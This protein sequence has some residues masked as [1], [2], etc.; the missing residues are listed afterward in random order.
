MIRYDTYRSNAAEL[1]VMRRWVFCGLALSLLIHAGILYYFYLHRME[2]AVFA[3][4]RLAPPRVFNMKRVSLPAPPP[5]PPAVERIKVPDKTATVTPITIPQD[6]PIVGEVRVAPQITDLAAKKVF[7]EK[8]RVDMAALDQMTK[9][10]A[11]SRNEMEKELNN[12]AQSL[13]KESPRS[14]RQPVIMASG[15][16]PAAAGKG[17]SN[18]SIPG[19]ASVDDMLSH[20][21][22][23]H[24]GDKAGM[25]GGALFEYDSYSL[26]PEAVEAMEKLGALIRNNPQATFAI[27][28]HTDSFGPPDYNQVLSEMRAAAVRDWLVLNLHIDPV[29]IQTRGFGNTRPL[30]PA[31]RS[32]EEQAPNRRVEIVVK[33]NRTR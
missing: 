21:G 31:D 28:G 9:A 2:G 22:S 19:L 13:I 15:G 3:A 24:A 14:P 5:E 6:K 23:L 29:R 18:V 1:P 30:V 17:D 12:I 8:P 7:D 26:R 32:K 10:N 27:E 4:E 25:P 16:G 20:T 11:S 33:T